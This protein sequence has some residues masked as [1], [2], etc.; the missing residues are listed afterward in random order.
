MGLRAVRA[1]APSRG[2]VTMQQS[3]E[4]VGVRT[5]ELLGEQG[6]C[7]WQCEVLD[8]DVILVVD[9]TFTKEMPK[10]HEVYTVR[11]LFLLLKVDETTIRLVHEAKKLGGAVVLEVEQLPEGKDPLR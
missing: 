1:E 10:E 9:E 4:E 8:G 3:P 2:R 6:W 11:E 5:S 7:L